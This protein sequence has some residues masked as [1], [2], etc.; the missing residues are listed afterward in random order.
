MPQAGDIILSDDIPV[1]VKRGRRTTA[2]GNITTTETGVLRV[3]DIPV[4][5]GWGY[6]ILT[7]NINLDTSVGNDIASVRLRVAFS[8]STG[9][10]A[11]TSSTLINQLRN[12]IDDATNS[13]VLPLS[14]NYFATADGYI[15]VLLSAIRQAGTGNIVVFCSSTEILDLVIEEMGEDPGDSGVVI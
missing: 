14:G 9:T 3:D 6:R 5:N 4:R 15:S 10:A 7:S 1:I 13:N 2:T 12:T 11:T 8:A